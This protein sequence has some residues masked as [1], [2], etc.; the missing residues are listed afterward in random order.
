MSCVLWGRCLWQYAK[1]VVLFVVFYELS[2]LSVHFFFI[3][4]LSDCLM[5]FGDGG[6]SHGRL[7]L[8]L[9]V[10]LS[11]YFLGVSDDL[12]GSFGLI[13]RVLDALIM[14]FVA[15]WCRT[16]CSYLLWI[17]CASMFVNTR[18]NIFTLC[19][20]AD[21]DSISNL[22]GLCDKRRFAG[23][24]IFWLKRCGLALRRNLIAGLHSVWSI[25]MNSNRLLHN[26][27][28]NFRNLFLVHL[29]RSLFIQVWFIL[30]HSV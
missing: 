2:M 4:G 16:R 15:R 14:L 23:P 5:E 25:C 29:W 24:I 18:S 17:M 19:R 11:D 10:W 12:L 22:V 9:F 30:A 6:H 13:L 27:S 20:I 28:C 7:N 21:Y 26:L 3:G 1:A 8:V